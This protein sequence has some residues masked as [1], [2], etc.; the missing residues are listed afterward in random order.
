MKKILLVTMILFMLV[1]NACAE[2]KTT[3]SEDTLNW[4]SKLEEAEKEAVETGNPIFVH[5]T[6]S[7]WCKWCF[8]LREEVYEKQAFIDYAK[9]NLVLLKLDFPRRTYQAEEVKRYNRNLLNR[10]GIRG[11]PTVLLLDEKGNVIAKTGYQYGGPDA[12]VA[13]LEELLSKN[14]K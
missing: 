13:H 6:G 2:E 4:Y 14:R 5:F 9:D 12:Y 8:K 11:F 7:D 3:K 1:L 10:Y